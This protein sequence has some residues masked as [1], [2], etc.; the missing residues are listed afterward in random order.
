MNAQMR[1]LLKWQESSVFCFPKKISYLHLIVP[2]LFGWILTGIAVAMGVVGQKFGSMGVVGQRFGS[3]GPTVGAE[4]EAVDG[5]EEEEMEKS[6]C[7]V[8]ES[9]V[10]FFV[11]P[12]CFFIAKL[13]ADFSNKDDD[14]MN[15]FDLG[16]QR[17]DVAALLLLWAFRLVFWISVR[18]F[19]CSSFSR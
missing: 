19:S 7:K 9:L 13:G 12:F 4:K 18:V 11:D 6:A 14:E 8:V 3:I 17:A 16:L 10:L 1:Y 5:A 15:T 2:S